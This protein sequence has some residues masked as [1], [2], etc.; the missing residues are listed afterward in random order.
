MT[1]DRL[2]KAAVAEHAARLADDEGLEAVTI[3]RLAKDL[4]VTPMA[5][6]WHFKNKEELLLGVVDHLL[7]G[8]RSEAADGDPWQKR[9]RALVDTVVDVMRRHP[10]LPDLMH[11][12]DK[13]RTENFTRA[14]NDCLALLSEAGF[15]LGEAF[16][17]SQ[18]LLTG[19][20]GLVSGHPGPR[21]GT[22]P[23]EAAELRRQK[24]LMFE[25]LPADRF[26][27]MVEYAATFRDE[28]DVER[29]FTF[30]VDLLLAGVE[31]TA[32]ARARRQP[33]HPAAR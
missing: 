9:L 31:A 11:A 3:R 24:R 22:S 5:L 4:G 28:P 18:H 2:S 25:C 23:E 29:Y 8:V 21:P 1:G 32:A 6:Y 13:T 20:I 19:V 14:T 26:P 33:D 10:A 30:N 15:T 12:V 17:V 27:K 16:W 7:G